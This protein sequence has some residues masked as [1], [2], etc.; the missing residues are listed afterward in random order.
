MKLHYFTTPLLKHYD[1]QLLYYS[2][3]P[4]LHC[5]TNILRQY[6]TTALPHLVT[7]LHA[8]L[9]LF[10]LLLLSALQDGAV[11]LRVEEVEVGTARTRTVAEPVGGELQKVR[12][13]MPALLV[14]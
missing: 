6:Y 10:L 14:L 1:T 13:V 9:N 8:T 5:F 4:L 2:T 12:Q 11:R 3:I 7:T